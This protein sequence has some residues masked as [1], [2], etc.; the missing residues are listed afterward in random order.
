ML[1]YPPLLSNKAC[2][3]RSLPSDWVSL[4]HFLPF[5]HWLLTM[6]DWKRVRKSYSKKMFT[7]RERARW[8]VADYTH[9]QVVG[10]MIPHFAMYPETRAWEGQSRRQAEDRT[11]SARLHRAAK[12]EEQGAWRAVAKALWLTGEAR[13][14]AQVTVLLCYTIKGREIT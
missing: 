4:W 3:V 2:C 7:L 12:A 1:C 8:V 6:I 9:M 14:L 5:S 13:A 11:D 10:Q